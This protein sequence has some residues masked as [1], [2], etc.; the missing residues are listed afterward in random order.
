MEILSLIYTQ[1]GF[2]HKRNH[3]GN[4]KMGLITNGYK[5]SLDTEQLH[6]SILYFCLH[7]GQFDCILRH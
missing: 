5:T 2:D 7:E 1:L 4:R 6:S 3:N